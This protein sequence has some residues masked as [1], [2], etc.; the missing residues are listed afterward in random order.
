VHVRKIP[1]SGDV[2]L[3]TIARGTPGMA[4]AD[5]ANLVNEAALLA[6][7]KNKT[8][9]DMSDFEEA[10]DKVML[11]VERKS[12]V[13]SEDERKLTAYHEAGHTVVSIMTPGSD[14]IHKV[15]IVPRGRALGLMMSLPEKD[16]Y[17]QTKEW[18]IGRLAISFGGR[19]AEELVFGPDKVTTGAGS[20]IEQATSLAR[21]MVTQ[22]GMSEKIG[23]MAVGEREHEVFLG[24]EF[25]TRREVSERTAEVVD[26][27]VKRFIDE[28]YRKATHILTEHRELLERIA[29][30][31]LDRETVDRD[32][33]ERIVRGETLPPRTP[34]LPPASPVAAVPPT[35]PAP[36]PR[37]PGILGAPGAEPAGA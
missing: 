24:R 19:V 17:G 5:L 36:A 15:T 1:L 10:K 11:G 23:M 18:L 3:A 33:L 21:R 14:P 22:F 32:D 27:E 8:L 20:D 9:V 29:L 16:R 30:T 7:R 37:A 6:A 2:E 28:A 31:L 13:L 25:G 4:G 35:K 12:L 26:D 34:T